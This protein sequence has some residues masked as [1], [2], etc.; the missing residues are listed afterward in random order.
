MSITKFKES[1][2]P[3]F[4]SSFLVGQHQFAEKCQFQDILKKRD[5][6]RAEESGREK[7]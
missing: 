7:Q 3:S 5:E 6:K 4:W 2:E 1:D